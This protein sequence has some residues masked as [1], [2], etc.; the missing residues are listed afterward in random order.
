MSLEI[1]DVDPRGRA[2]RLFIE[3]SARLST[4]IDDQLRRDAG[5]ALADYHV[6]LLLSEAPG[7]RLRMKE[8]A[9]RMVFSQS[10][11]TYQVD[12]LCKRGWLRREPVPEDRRGSYA[13][14]TDEGRGAFAAAARGHRELVD[15]LFYD[16]LTPD[17]GRELAGLMA[18]LA[19]RLQEHRD[20]H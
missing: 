3:T 20:D 18:R 10:R 13:I 16:A 15:R 17:D 4:A 14:L 8:I 12:T 7:H 11:L 9:E 19:D 5:M 2:W 1:E 6:L